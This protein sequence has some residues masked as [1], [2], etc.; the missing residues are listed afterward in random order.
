[1]GQTKPSLQPRQRRVS[2]PYEVVLGFGKKE[3]LDESRRC[4]QCA[5]PVCLKGC[6]LGIDIPGFIRLLREDD[7]AAALERIRRENPFPA[8]CGRI[9]PAPCEPACIFYEDGTP[10][11][12]RDLERYA[13]DF[14]RGKLQK[15]KNAPADK[16]KKV[17]IIGAGPSGM[18]AAWYLARAGYGVTLFEA[19]H[20]P[21]GLLRYGVPEF[22]L[23]Q[24]ILDEYTMELK[25]MG[26]R[27]ETN[28]LAGGTEP[29]LDILGRGYA[30]MLL[31]VGAGV[32]DLTDFPGHNL[33]GVYYA[34][35]F[36][37]RAQS[38]AKAKVLETGRDLML[39]AQT[40]VLG[41]GPS[42]LDAARL[43]VRLGQQVDLIF[44]G[45][46]EELGVH[47]DDLKAAVEEGVKVHAPVKPLGIEPDARGFAGAV[48]CRRLE[49]VEQDG[50]LSLQPVADG[51]ILIE[52]QTVI[53]SHGRR[54]NPFLRRGLPQLQY[55]DNGTLWVDAQTGLT[56]LE[57]IFAAGNA[58]TG[59]GPVVDAIAGGKAAA[60]KI[61]EFLS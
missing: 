32:P 14:G 24:K 6:P 12:I 18:A 25:G 56:N 9:C 40:A 35:E 53:L 7:T 19:M 26:V 55:N 48:A 28:I 16:G 11:A 34:E 41:F 51:E 29:V 52:A 5:Q 31:T 60:K 30:A 17:A 46:E 49:M 61:M 38:G 50:K 13:A 23:P 37:M 58:V 44:G 43:A 57:N 21:G 54:P 27:I 22:R 1:M 15:E 3:N 10:I 42:A 33:G 8:I 2:N 45:P 36:L 20:E 59:A 4:P 39:G 47:A